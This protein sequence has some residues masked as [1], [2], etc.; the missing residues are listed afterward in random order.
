MKKRIMKQIILSIIAM[1]ALL[2]SCHEV[3]CEAPAAE[4]PATESRVVTFSSGISTRVS[5]DMWDADDVIGVYMFEMQNSVCDDSENV[6]YSLASGVGE[7]TAT[8]F[9][10]E[11][12]ELTYPYG[13]MYYD[14]VAYLPYSD[15]VQDYT[16]AINTADQTSAEKIA[17][18]D[19]MTAMVEGHSSESDSDPVLNFSRMMSKVIFKVDYGDEVDTDTYNSVS[20]SGALTDGSLLIYNGGPRINTDA[21]S[22][23]I[24]SL[25][26]DSEFNASAIVI[27]QDEVEVDVE[28]NRNVG[29]GLIATIKQSFVAG[30]QYT[31]TLRLSRH[32]VEVSGCTIE[33]WQNEDQDNLYIP[34]N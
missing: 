4:S 31:Y 6:P 24:M 23:S 5:G 21:D 18:L 30:K 26:I 17:N 29:V 8:F 34:S 15:Q 32:E 10:A 14:F 3:V 20:L 27:P 25:Y 1:G 16:L 19:I 13:D 22:G 28:L 11:D 12:K 33:D 7:Q 9:P 2:V